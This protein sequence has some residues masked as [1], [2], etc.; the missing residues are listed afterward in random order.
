MR[1]GDY[2]EASRAIIRDRPEVRRA[3]A[4]A[5]LHFDR[6]R[7]RGYWSIDSASW[8]GWARDVKAHALGRLGRYLRLAEERLIARGAKVHWARDGS[9][10]RRIV[11]RIL[12]EEGAKRVVKGKSMVTEEIGLNAALAEGGAEVVE[13]DLGEYILQLLDEPPSHIVGPAIHKSIESVRALFREHLGTSADAD[14]VALARAARAA[15]R[16]R[17]LA[18]DAGITG[19]N[20]LVAETGTLALIENEGNIRLST[21]L[22]NVHIALVGIEKVLPSLDDLARFLQLTAR[23]ATGQPISAFASLIQGPARRKGD[24][25][26]KEVHVVLLDNGRS[27]LLADERAS[28]ALRC[29]RC[30]ACLNVCPVFRQTGGHAYGWVYSG[31]IGSILAPGLLGLEESMPLPF[32]SSLCGACEDVCPVKIP[33]PDLLLYW[34]RRAQEAGVAPAAGNRIM[35]LLAEA[36]RR[37]AL[38]RAAGRAMR[39]LGG[40][41]AAKRLPLL[42][43]WSR[44]REA[45]RPSR[46]S[47]RELW[48]KGIS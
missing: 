15:L 11:L 39:R 22:P 16:E 9:E 47:F 12:A 24:D 27:R 7:D 33:I 10:A 36:A 20:F 40:P 23:A 42:S 29:V 37:P 41:H 17:F 38:Y 32:A 28:E 34:R 3:V 26:P 31:P 2:V 43:D 5:T 18:A 44:E 30:G 6:K 4:H 8:R 25:G 45:P 19:G 13:T 48:K 21:S 35:K 46:A 1:P 14:P